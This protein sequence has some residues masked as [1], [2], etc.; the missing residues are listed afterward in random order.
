MI[1]GGVL[2][3]DNIKPTQEDEDDDFAGGG[4]EDLDYEAL[5]EEEK[6]A[7]L[8][9]YQEE[10][11]RNP[12]AFDD[13]QRDFII[14]ELQRLEGQHEPPREQETDDHEPMQP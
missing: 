1:G 12:G 3:E 6:Y 9:Q 11:F 14:S 8:Q 5:N 13:Q 2:N 4:D 10:L 7:V